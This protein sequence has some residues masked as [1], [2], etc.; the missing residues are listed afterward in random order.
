MATHRE[1]VEFQT[2]DGLTIKG[3]LY[4]ASKR[5]PGVIMTPGVC[6]SFVG[7]YSKDS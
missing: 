7:V 6:T 4:P 3:W 2:L 5:G 1:D